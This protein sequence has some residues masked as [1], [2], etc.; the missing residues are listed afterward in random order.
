MRR[1][2]F[3]EKF[4]G[5]VSAWETVGDSSIGY[6]TRYTVQEQNGS[7]SYVWLSGTPDD[8]I[9]AEGNSID[10]GDFAEVVFPGFFKKP[11]INPLTAYVIVKPYNII[12]GT[13]IPNTKSGIVPIPHPTSD[14]EP[15]QVDISHGNL[16]QLRE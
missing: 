12:D 11:K 16:L 2:L 15:S 4:F 6:D 1:N 14:T 3:G 7:N 8:Q 10:T 13:R 9:E 5:Y